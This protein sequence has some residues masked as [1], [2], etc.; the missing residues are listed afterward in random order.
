MKFYSL[1]PEENEGQGVAYAPEGVTFRALYCKGHIERWR[2]ID[3]VLRDGVF[4]DY[5]WNNLGW[6]MCSEKL[7]Q[8]LAECAG[9]ND[10]IQWLPVTIRNADGERRNYSVLH[11]P[12]ASDV[13]STTQ[14]IM[15]GDIVVKP[16]LDR[17]KIHGHS[18]FTFSNDGVKVYID[19]PTRKQIL[20]AA[21]TGL[22]F[23]RVS[24]GGGG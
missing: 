11:I 6:H 2:P 12:I 20:A 23:L 5:Q 1:Y 15:S 19:E 9:P 3:F 18:I 16:V 21:V 13:L 24:V 7:E 14:T 10:V 8:V 17:S 22:D 4:T